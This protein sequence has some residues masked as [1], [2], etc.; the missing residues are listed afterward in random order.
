M[1]I[2]RFFVNADP[3]LDVTPMADIVFLLIIFFMISSTLVSEPGVKLTLPKA[4]TAEIQS[5][6]KLIVS[7]AA[8]RTISVGN[9]VVSLDQLEDELRLQLSTRREK[10]VV[11]RADKSVSHGLVV[12][13]LDAAKVTGAQTL[14]LAAEVKR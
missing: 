2:K 8:D 1:K 9:R 5:D 12:T 13:V 4:K 10:F 3:R 14:A 7:I 11:I 6:D